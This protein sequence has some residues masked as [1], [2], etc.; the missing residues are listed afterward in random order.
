MHFL[1]RR[2]GPFVRCRNQLSF[3]WAVHVSIFERFSSLHGSKLLLPEVRG[4]LPRP[5]RRTSWQTSAFIVQWEALHRILGDISTPRVPIP[6][7][8]LRETSSHFA[9]IAV[10]PTRVPIGFCK[11]SRRS[12]HEVSRRSPRMGWPGENESSA[13]SK[14]VFRTRKHVGNG[15]A[16][17][18]SDDAGH[19][20]PEDRHM[21]VHRRFCDTPETSPMRTYQIK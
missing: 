8:S 4:S 20:R 15:A 10:V 14:F 16:D 1:L 18:R 3:T 13:Y 17:D 12:E 5:K 9:A 2:T 11:R 21:H 7:F 6:R 19:D